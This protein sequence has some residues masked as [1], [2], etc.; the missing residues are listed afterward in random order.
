MLVDGHHL[1]DVSVASLRETIGT[2]P[3]DTLLLNRL[4]GENLPR[5]LTGRR[6]CHCEPRLR[7]GRAEA[8]SQWR[9]SH[10]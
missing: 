4:I 3:Q 6:H 2:G 8:G 10:R 1:H 5:M 7:R 9:R